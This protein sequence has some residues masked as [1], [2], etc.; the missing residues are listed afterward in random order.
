MYKRHEP[1]SSHNFPDYFNL[2]DMALNFGDAD[3][4]PELG[5][6]VQLEHITVEYSAFRGH[7]LF[8]CSSVKALRT[9]CTRLLRTAQ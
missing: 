5:V 8:P 9:Y 1:K 4:F 2:Q 7:A 6:W 3:T